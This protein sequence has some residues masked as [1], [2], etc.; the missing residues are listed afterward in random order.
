MFFMVGE[1]RWRAEKERCR[2]ENECVAEFLHS[3]D[4]LAR[5]DNRVIYSC[6]KVGKLAQK[7]GFLLIVAIVMA[8]VIL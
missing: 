1:E 4:C 3:V 2:C 5:E 8:I 7:S 6:N